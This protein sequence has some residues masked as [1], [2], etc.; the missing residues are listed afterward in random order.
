MTALAAYLDHDAFASHE[1]EEAPFAWNAPAQPELTVLDA[2]E[3][4]EVLGI[5]DFVHVAPHY[6]KRPYFGYVEAI[7]GERVT[8]E[9]WSFGYKC[10]HGIEEVTLKL[11]KAALEAETANAV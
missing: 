10:Q 1:H 5:G 8:V 6:N 11:S 2:P 9:H 7:D 3:P 4:L